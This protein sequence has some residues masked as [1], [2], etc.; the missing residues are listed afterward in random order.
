[1]FFSISAQFTAGFLDRR[2]RARKEAASS[3]AR[4]AEFAPIAALTCFTRN[5]RK[6]GRTGIFRGPVKEPLM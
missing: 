5:F 1:V 2:K 4:A 6:L 3:L